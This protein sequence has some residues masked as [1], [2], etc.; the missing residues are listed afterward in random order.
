LKQLVRALVVTFI[1]ALIAVTS[2]V[3]GSMAQAATN[4]TIASFR[5]SGSPF[6]ADLAP[7]PTSVAAT[8]TLNRRAKVTVRVFTPGGQLVRTLA[9]R[10]GTAAGTRTWSWNGLDSAGH[11]AADGLYDVQVKVSNSL[12]TIVAKRRLRKGL[13]SIFPAN[14]AAIVIAVDPG[15]GGRYTGA[16]RNGWQEKDFNLDIGLRLQALLEHAGVQVVMSRTTDNALDEPPTDR[17]GDGVFDRYDDDLMRNDSAN[18]AR[19]DVAVHVHNNAS[20]NPNGHGTKTFTDGNRTWTPEGLA[21]SRLV[22]EEEFAVLETYRSPEFTP[23]DGGTHFG[24]YYYMGPYDPPFLVRPALVTSVLSESLYVSNPAE[25]E[26]LKRTDVRTSLAAAIYVGLARWLNTRDLGIGYELV[27]GPA[28]SVS[29]GSNLSYRLKVTNRGNESSDG[30]TL[31]LHSVPSVP[32]YDGSGQ[33]G[34]LMGSVSVPDGLQPG[35][36]VELDV[37][38]SAPSGAGEWLVKS[39][40]R[41][42]DNSY[43]SAAGVVSLQTALTTVAP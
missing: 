4:N 5:L 20:T 17:N 9:L 41:L 40:V 35:A 23:R 6:A 31:Q 34:T 24:W 19:A 38:A 3:P 25:L 21:V 16:V 27:S 13:P 26:A 10:R 15:H 7:L 39:D 22:R 36:S 18:L 28:A 37:A 32:V 12:G 14:P 43:A 2:P 1:L 11:T 42:S 33:L 29:A 30:W 8:L